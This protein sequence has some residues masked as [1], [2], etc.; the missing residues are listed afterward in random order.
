MDNTI[1]TGLLFYFIRQDRN[2]KEISSDGADC[3]PKKLSEY[4][5]RMSSS[6]R[7]DTPPL[8]TCVHSA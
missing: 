8:T 5:T 7:H 1:W 4:C 2:Y 6:G 3:A